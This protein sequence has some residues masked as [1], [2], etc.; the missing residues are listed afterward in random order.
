M[1]DAFFHHIVELLHRASGL[2][3]T[4]IGEEEKNHISLLSAAFTGDFAERGRLCQLVYLYPRF[5]KQPGEIVIA[6]P[7][8]VNSFPSSYL[9]TFSTAI[10]GCISFW[11]CC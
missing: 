8:E 3:P 5:S 4:H 1:A 9:E 2:T 6:K 11:T 7:H 10:T